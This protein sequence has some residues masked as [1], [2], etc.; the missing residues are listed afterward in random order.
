MAFKVFPR[1]KQTFT[2]TGTGT[3]TLGAASTGYQ[4]VAA[5]YSDGDTLPYVME[6]GADWEIGYGT[7][8][9]TGTTIARSVVSSSNG[10]ALVNFPAGTKTFAVAENG[11]HASL[12]PRWA[13]FTAPD[14]G[15]IGTSGT[16]APV[17]TGDAYAAMG[18]AAIATGTSAIALGTQNEAVAEAA[19]SV[20]GFN[21][22]ATQESAACFGGSSN[23]A[24][25][26]N[27]LAAG[28]TSNTAS[29][30]GAACLGGEGNRAT[31]K[32][33]VALGGGNHYSVSWAGSVGSG[34]GTFD[35]G[36]SEVMGHS[37][38][39]VARETT[40]ATETTLGYDGDPTTHTLELAADDGV[41]VVQGVAGAFAAASGD[42][43]TWSVSA[44]I[45]VAAGVAS[46]IDAPTITVLNDTAGAAAWDFQLELGTTPN[47]L[48]P[49][50]T[51]AAATTITWG[52]HLRVLTVMY[53]AP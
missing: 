47:R 52:A 38:V 12:F 37:A 18:H 4:A 51:G 36:E 13:K 40:D 14:N 49:R 25:A 44:S 9:G 32:G 29:G 26:L 5:R 31:A 43:K 15:T 48:L 30:E 42:A 22:N 53:F 34:A 23:N 8:G 28:G 16:T 17:L 3:V 41:Y 7:V 24:Q 39:M 46:F 11:I 33:S 45:V 50:G 2:T 20:G 1:I 19:V 6:L 35:A 21:N 10:D 27:A